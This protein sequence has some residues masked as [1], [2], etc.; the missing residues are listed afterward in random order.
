VG[1][2]KVSV[3]LG[4]TQTFKKF[5]RLCESHCVPPVGHAVYL[6]LYAAAVIVGAFLQH[7]F[8][9]QKPIGDGQPSCQEH[10]KE[11]TM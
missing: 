10:G 1:A 8:Y 11:A 3:N 6:P 2:S 5:G 9:E 4:P 7:L